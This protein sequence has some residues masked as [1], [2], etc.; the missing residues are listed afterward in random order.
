MKRKSL[1]VFLILGILAIV[2]QLALAGTVTVAGATI[3]TPETYASCSTTPFSDSIS[4]TGVNGRQ[5]RGQVFANFV[6]G[7]T[8]VQIPG[9]YYSIDQ[10][11]D[12][13]LTI[14]Y[15]GV[16]DW[17]L[18]SPGLAE[19]H[20]VVQLELFENGVLVG[21]LG[22]GSVWDVFC[23][24]PPP[25]PPPPPPGNQGCTPGYWKQDQH[26]DSWAAP[27]TPT[28][29]FASV[30]GRNVDGAPTLL[31]GLGLNGGGLN[32]LTRHAVAALL[33][34]QS[35]G[36]ASPYSTAQVISMFQVAYDT[37]NYEPTKNQFAAANELGC[38]LN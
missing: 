4:V 2:P 11:T 27:Y 25:P 22:P 28:T 5:L 14:T 9:Q 31:A 16:Q 34:A 17:P 8:L 1:F 6:V 21:T 30:F 13:F 29:P 32:A 12:L 15:P 10:T 20:V 7:Q 36:V 37:G 3:V 23:N 35:D 18:Q 33:N 38:P 24:N 19:V 26:F